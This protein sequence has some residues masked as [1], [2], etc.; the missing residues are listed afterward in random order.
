MCLSS[1]SISD[2]SHTLI[3]NLLLVQANT[4]ATTYTIAPS[5]ARPFRRSH[6]ASPVPGLLSPPNSPSK[7]ALRTDS[8]QSGI[9]SRHTWG[10]Q[11]LETLLSSTTNFYGAKTSAS[12]VNVIRRSLKQLSHSLLYT[13]DLLTS[14]SLTC[15]EV[16]LSCSEAKNGVSRAFFHPEI[17]S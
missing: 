13:D 10:R 1:L 4:H 17:A 7:T 3:P 9:P 12:K 11:H 6:I 2:Q 5:C 15:K 14:L 16:G 8:A